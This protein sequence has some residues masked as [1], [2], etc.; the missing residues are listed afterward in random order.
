ML[1]GQRIALQIGRPLEEN[2]SAWIANQ[3]RAGNEQP[4]NE[5]IT[6]QAKVHLSSLIREQQKLT[7]RLSEIESELE[8]YA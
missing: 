1:W 5:W 2:E 3:L 7:Q 8:N 4:V 6:E